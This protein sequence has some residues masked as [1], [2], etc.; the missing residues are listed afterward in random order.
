MKFNFQTICHS[1]LLRDLPARQK[2]VLSRRF[3]LKGEKETL[4]AVGRAYGITRERVRQIEK[5][6]L[7]RLEDRIDNV[8]CQKVFQA[9]SKELKDSGGLKREDILLAKL[10]GAK[11][12]NPVLFLLTLG[13]PFEKI[14]ETGD[15]HSFWT[16]DKNSF[17]A[18]RKHI[19]A[20]IS[21]LKRKQKPLSLPSKLS[22]SYIEISKNILKGP[23]DLY[24]LKNWPEINPRG[25]KDK[26]YI[27]FKKEE[28]I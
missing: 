22:L 9:F 7:K 2:D 16:I 17:N 21:E 19:S 11:F 4:E 14:S 24:G 28:M 13:K 15:F 25:I 26:A 10:G 23:Q 1:N 27:V 6:G 8:Q 3:G 12:Q 5:E 18:A 20:F